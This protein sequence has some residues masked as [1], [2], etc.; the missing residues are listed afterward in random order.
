MPRNDQVSV[1][2]G[3]AGAQGGRWQHCR[4]KVVR[5]VECLFGHDAQVARCGKGLVDALELACV[6]RAYGQE[7]V[8][9]GCRAG[10]RWQPPQVA[11][12]NRGDPRRVL[13][14]VDAVGSDEQV[15][16]RVSGYGR[17]LRDALGIVARQC[18]RG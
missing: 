9:S 18:L 4:P 13:W 3:R 12:C 16:L 1:W 7:Q 8:Q 2:N 6:S 10:W 15:V 14:V 5:A 11:A 17:V